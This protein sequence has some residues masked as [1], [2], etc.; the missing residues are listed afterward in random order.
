MRLVLP[1]PF[2]ELSHTADA[3]VRVRGATAEET[4]ARLVCVF[5]RLLGGTDALTPT[6]E[7]RLEVEGGDPVLA[8][9]D[10]LRELLFRFDAHGRLPASAEVL[11]LDPERVV[12]RVGL[13]PFD[14][15]RHTE[16]LPLKAVTLH[17]ARFER[18]P[19]GWV[20][21]VVFDV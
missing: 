20:A 12:V 16:G 9:V 7:A 15:D 3:A 5:G 2:E 1:Q 14:P 19:R 10:V 4:L 8:M 11:R 17:H 18:T 21:E 6:E 13:A